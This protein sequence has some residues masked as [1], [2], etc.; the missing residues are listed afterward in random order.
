MQL[1]L[2]RAKIHRA[3]VTEADVDYEGSIGIDAQLLR[4]AD[5]V[6][7]ELVH[8]WNITNGSRLTTYAIE[9][10]AWSGSIKPNGAAALHN[11]PGDLIIIAAFGRFEKWEARLFQPTVVLVNDKN[12]MTKVMH[13][14]KLTN[15]LGTE[16]E[17]FKVREDPWTNQSW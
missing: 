9:A 1:E 14:S 12:Q 15:P 6:P 2:V 13:A 3:T 10:E 17:P 7:Y 11:R 8:V 16:T 5:I 4:E